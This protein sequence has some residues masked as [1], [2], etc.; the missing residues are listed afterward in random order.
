MNG[1]K[2]RK[3]YGDLLEL[4]LEKHTELDDFEAVA[5]IARNLGFEKAESV[6]IHSTK[7]DQD[8]MEHSSY[9]QN[10]SE[11]PAQSFPQTSTADRPLLPFYHIVKRER[12]ERHLKPK[13]FEKVAW[14]EKIKSLNGD[15]I[16]DENA[17]KPKWQPLTR[18]PKIWA[19]LRHILKQKYLSN[20]PDIPKLVKHIE[21]G[22]SLK[23]FPY[24]SQH[25]R[26]SQIVVL[27][28]Y[29]S[30]L[31]TCRTD[32]QQLQ[33]R[34][35]KY[36]G[37]NRIIWQKIEDYPGGMI[38]IKQHE[39]Y[40]EKKWVTPPI[41]TAILILSDCGALADKATRQH[42]QTF[43][44]KTKKMGNTLL[45]LAPASAADLQGIN[46]KGVHA[47]SWDN[48][49]ARSG[50]IAHQEPLKDEKRN[51]EDVERLLSFLSFTYRIEPHLLR[52]SRKYLGL[53]V[54]IEAACRTYE[55]IDDDGE[56]LY[57]KPEE[58]S[59]Y[60][61]IFADSETFT[62]KQQAKA[63]QLVRNTHAVLPRSI[64]DVELVT[65][66]S[67][68]PD[69]EIAGANEALHY[70]RRRCKT[71][72]EKAN[73]RLY[74]SYAYY[75]LL[76]QEKGGE[77]AALFWVT[78]YKDLVNEDD[79]KPIQLPKNVNLSDVA[80]FIDI[81]QSATFYRLEQYANQLTF[82][83]DQNHNNADVLIS[84]RFELGKSEFTQRLID[85]DH[86]TVPVN[87]EIFIE[88]PND[89]SISIDTGTES[90]TIATLTKPD[91]A[92]NIGR[93][94][95][96][97]YLEAGH[98]G[99][100]TRVYY[101][102]WGGTLEQ[103]ENGIYTEITVKGISQRFRYITAGTFLMGSP[104]S[105][106]DRSSD[107]A[108]HEVTLSSGYWLAD[109]ACTQALWQTVMGE[110]PARFN[111]DLQN[112]VEQ[113][114]WDEVQVFIKKL[115]ELIPELSAQ[116]PTEAQWEYACRAG[117]TTPFTFGENISP[118]QVNYDGGYPYANGK[119]GLDREKTVPVKAL[120][121]N[122]WG[123]Y[124]MHGNVYE[125]CQDWYGDYPTSPVQNPEGAETS[126]YR[127][128][129]GGSWF[130]FGQDVRSADRSGDTPDNRDYDFGFRLS[131]GQAKV[132]AV[133]DHDSASDQRSTR[134]V[135]ASSAGRGFIEQSVGKVRDLFKKT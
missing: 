129:R 110:N 27:A 70:L 38:S 56:F 131:L 1:L 104:T 107:E 127:V 29:A 99:Q 63:I 74:Q 118:E 132:E 9:Q 42:W 16:Y 79:S 19:K 2:S 115:N 71:F 3:S 43:L 30:H 93:D 44:Q 35:N 85:V 128:L 47:Y 102:E 64:L 98:Q 109:T 18:P 100:Q 12:L 80:R 48:D 57:L 130:D 96:G 73:D 124:Q 125:W 76:D 103:D 122:E 45:L 55:H 108:Q 116:L 120:A 101:P 72:T 88:M 7:N 117:T 97:L 78:L 21:K 114:S 36:W 28:D 24:T 112:P 13:V 106:I 39:D 59:R 54:S 32:Y 75:Y 126:V 119:K 62:S 68:L 111:E 53:P 6:P 105:E 11:S 77:E 4:I 17:K 84:N 69:H 121:K 31:R 92:E 5:K 8:L 113:V 34:L 94:A 123:L 25:C 65:V 87:D 15:D 61:G 135:A 90:L 33:S 91:W 60:R 10:K 37:K 86:Q 52:A 14:L 51:K 134:A 89:K 50:G 58:L 20:H 41:D 46:L 95:Q 83:K 23:Y 40:Q 66:Q 22:D 49:L 67:L 81:N 26:V 133:A 82:K